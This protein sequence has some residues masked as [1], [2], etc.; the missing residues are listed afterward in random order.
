MSVTAKNPA[1]HETS[2]SIPPGLTLFDLILPPQAVPLLLLLLLITPL[3]LL[4]AEN[5]F[6]PFYE[7]ATSRMTQ[8]GELVFTSLPIYY[9]LK[10]G[11]FLV[12]SFLGGVQLLLR[13][14]TIYYSVWAKAF[15]RPHPLHVDYYPQKHQSLLALMGWKFFRNAV[16]ILPPIVMVALSGLVGLIELYLFNTFNEL[17]FVSLSFQFIVS[18]FI[19]LL[20]MMFTGF[21]FLNSLWTLFTT[22]FGDIIAVTEPDLP[23][24]TIY[25][26]C[27]RIAFSSPYIYVLYPAYLLFGIGFLA[28]VIL[29]FSAV[30][31]QELI[32]FQA[33]IPLIFGFEVLTLGFYMALNYLKFYTYHHSL[34]QYYHKLPKQLKECFTPPPATHGEDIDGDIRFS[35]PVQEF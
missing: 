21:I 34:I 25:E 27:S 32:T 23:N 16:I 15:P 28:E 13:L 18:I 4:T 20:M 24:K 5:F 35:S 31:I 17:P 29:L 8:N 2:P 9:F 10:L 1:F 22:I 11:A 26:R 14:N 33:P 6:I 3:V 19:M 7:W 30:D 12:L